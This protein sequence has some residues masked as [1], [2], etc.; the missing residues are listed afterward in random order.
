MNICAVD[1]PAGSGELDRADLT[2]MPSVGVRSP[3]TA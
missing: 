3:R 1:F 2:V